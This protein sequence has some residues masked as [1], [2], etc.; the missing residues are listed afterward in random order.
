MTEIK[1]G[2]K[3]VY[4]DMEYPDADEMLIKAQLVT[5]IG[6]TIKARGW[7]QQKAAEVLGMT[8]PKL[9]DVLG[10]RFHGVSVAKLLDCMAR[11]NFRVQ[12]VIGEEM[13]SAF[14]VQ[15]VMS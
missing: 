12:I 14:P 6:K 11:L 5:K 4:A 15:L 8:Q 3:N 10:G 1:K 13:P 7:T 2:S 9:S